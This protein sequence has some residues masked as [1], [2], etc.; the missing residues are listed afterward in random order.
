MEFLVRKIEEKKITKEKDGKKKTVLV[1]K[2]TL[3]STGA[4]I[5]KAVITSEE[6]EY[7]YGDIV[8]IKAT[9][10]QNRLE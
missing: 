1:F 8:E 2:F 7:G 6:E 4:E 10:K 3:T 5:T 9:K